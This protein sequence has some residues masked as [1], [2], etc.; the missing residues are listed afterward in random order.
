MKATTK[1]A[2]R[3]ILISI[4]VLCLVAGV[5]YAVYIEKIASESDA[6]YQDY[7]EDKY[8]NLLS[9]ELFIDRLDGIETVYTDPEHIK[10][11][12]AITDDAYNIWLKRHPV[13]D[14]TRTAEVCAVYYTPPTR[15]VLL[16]KNSVYTYLVLLAVN[17]N[18]VSTAHYLSVTFENGTVTALT[19]II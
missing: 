16:D 14:V 11:N 12:I 2:L 13:V 3:I 6:I 9:Y 5:S 19:E 1:T 17:E 4:I 7:L 15:S 8:P 10:Q 18:S